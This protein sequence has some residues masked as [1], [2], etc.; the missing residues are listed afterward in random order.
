MGAI[1]ALLIYLACCSRGHRLQNETEQTKGLTDQL[2][3]PLGRPLPK[4][5]VRPGLHLLEHARKDNRNI[6]QLQPLRGPPSNAVD[7]SSLMARSKDVTVLKIKG[8]SSAVALTRSIGQLQPLQGLLSNAVDLRSLVARSKN[9]SIPKIKGLSSL[10]ALTRNIGQFK[11]LIARNKDV[12]IP[13]IKGLSSSTARTRNIGQLQPLRWLLSNPVDQRSLMARSK[14]VTIPKIKGLCSLTARTK[15]IYDLQSGE[16]LLLM[17]SDSDA[18]SSQ[19]QLENDA[20]Q[21]IQQAGITVV[22]HKLI[23]TINP[24]TGKI[25]K[26][27][28]Q[29]RIHGAFVKIQ[30]VG[31]SAVFH[32]GSS[33]LSKAL[34]EE[35]LVSSLALTPA[36]V[37]KLKDDLT[38]I[39]RSG[40]RI[41]DLQGIIQPDGHFVLIDPQGVT[42]PGGEFVGDTIYDPSSMSAWIL[43][44]E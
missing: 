12:T 41:E 21:A 17:K 39:E 13:R 23:N 2:G 31:K 18:E 37:I 19:L 14:D 22:P 24:R 27:M 44:H 7:Q 42:L 40:L 26:G 29:K 38:R 5:L 33:M 4:P 28:I 10:A 9:V 43:D 20:L 15:D 1:N 16:I 11:S 34:R 30:G 6:G 32:R 36:A 8:L 3:L 35:E 25:V